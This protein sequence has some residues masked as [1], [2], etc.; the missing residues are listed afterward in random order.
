L[1]AILNHIVMRLNP[2]WMLLA[3][4]FWLATH[5]SADQQC[6]GD[7]RKERTLAGHSQAVTSV[8]FSPNGKQLATA[9][10]DKSIKLWDVAE[11]RE[12]LSLKG[13]TENVFSVVFAPDGKTLVSSSADGKVKLWDRA[14]GKELRTL[15]D[16]APSI[17]FTPD[18]KTLLTTGN[19][20]SKLNFWDLDTGSL[21]VSLDGA[22]YGNGGIGVA[23]DG[24]TAVTGAD[25][26]VKI[27][28]LVSR[29]RIHTLR[30]FGSLVLCVAF[31][32]DGKLVASG[33]G[34]DKVKIWDVATGQQRATIEGHVG[35]VDCVA[36]APDGEVLAWGGLFNRVQLWD[37]AK[38]RK[39]TTLAGHTD[40]VD[41]LAFSPD[42]K[43]LATGSSDSTVRLWDLTKVIKGQR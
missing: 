5:L 34:E 11:G 30:G 17:A 33:D 1:S 20:E 12:V 23:S 16:H 25:K 2:N 22:H 32:P 40:S 19:Y 7:E 43:T 35:H 37:V 39:I 14:T 27:W 10:W 8:A 15:Q 36:F 9:S 3:G 38:S 6:L 24:K 31:S 42:G 4:I 29:K 26:A 41:A 18:G 21:R 28:D 13:H